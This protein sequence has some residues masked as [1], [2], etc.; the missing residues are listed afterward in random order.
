MNESIYH[1]KPCD[2]DHRIILPDKTIRVVHEM[3]EVAFNEAGRPT[4]MIGTVHDITER[5]RAEDELRALSHDLVHLQ[6]SERLKIGQQKKR[7]AG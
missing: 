1:G 7:A 3:G 2:V 5:K 4:S 6:E